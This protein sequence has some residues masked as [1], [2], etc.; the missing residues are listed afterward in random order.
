MC[1][2]NQDMI[3]T[4]RSSLRH[5]YFYSNHGPQKHAQKS[6]LQPVMFVVSLKLDN[7]ALATSL[8]LALLD[9]VFVI[10]YCFLESLIVARG[11]GKQILFLMKKQKTWG[12]E[13]Y[14]ERAFL[15]SIIN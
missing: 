7:P 3:P 15:L 9:V 8:W 6:M 1:E 13:E 2:L 14:L 12:H 10:Y 5:L 11:Q 4:S